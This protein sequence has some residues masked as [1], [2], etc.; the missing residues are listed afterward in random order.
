M[1]DGLLK[2]ASRISWHMILA[3]L[4]LRG[5]RLRLVLVAPSVRA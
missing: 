3:L 2:Q 1:S 4:F 5:N